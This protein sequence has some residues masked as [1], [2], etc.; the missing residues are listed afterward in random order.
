MTARQVRCLA[1]DALFCDTTL[2]QR[3]GLAAD[4]LGL[5]AYEVDGCDTEDLDAIRHRIVV[6][7]ARY[8]RVSATQAS[9]AGKDPAA[10]YA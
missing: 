1:W 9:L 8:L 5:D 6:L 10:Q 2:L 4:T 7:G 3:Q